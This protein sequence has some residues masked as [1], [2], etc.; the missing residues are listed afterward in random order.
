[1]L[2]LNSARIVFFPSEIEPEP[3]GDASMRMANYGIILSLIVLAGCGQNAYTLHSQN[4]ALAQQQQTLAQSGQELQ[5]RAAAL[6][7]DNQE[8]GNLLAQS[9]QQIQL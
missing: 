4:Q 2:L 9:R 6:D 3:M 8:L 1:L 5:A 7:K